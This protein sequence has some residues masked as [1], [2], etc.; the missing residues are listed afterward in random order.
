M[1][2][3]KSPRETSVN[4]APLP[5]D[6][7]ALVLEEIT[8]AQKRGIPIKAI[9][10]DARIPTWRLYEITE[11]RKRLAFDETGR[12]MDALRSIRLLEG[13]ARSVGAVVV[14]VRAEAEGHDDLYHAF[15]EAVQELAD[16]ARE[17]RVALGNDGAIDATEGAALEVLLDKLQSTVEG[18]RLIVRNKS[19]A[20]SAGASGPRAVQR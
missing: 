14:I 6:L 9:A 19:A 1:T 15:E 7:A 13:L 11:G 18:I 12:L 3:P 5:V 4:R 16:F 2:T 17:K 10:E 8:A 20:A